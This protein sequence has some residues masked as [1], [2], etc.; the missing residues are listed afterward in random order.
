[1]IGQTFS[2][3]RILEKIGGGGMGV[4]YKA[5]DSRLHRLVALKFLPEALARDPVAL[6]RFQ[7]EARAAS[8]L[9]H[10]NICT[11]HDIGEQDGRAFIVMEYVDGG[12]LSHRIA[13]RPLDTE[14]LLRFAIEIADVLATAHSAG[15]VHRD[16]KTAN[17]MIT[18]RGQAKVLDFGLAKLGMEREGSGSGPDDPTF[19]ASQLTTAGE[20]LGTVAY[21][22]PE[23][24]EGKNL[25]GRSDLFSFGAVLYEMATGRMAFEKPTKGST[26]GA[27]LHEPPPPATQFNP[28]IPQRLL[29][30]IDKALEKDR[31]LRY[32]TA[33]DVRNDL[34][35]LKRDLDSGGQERK[36][37]PANPGL[38]PG[39]TRG[40][41]PVSR[42]GRA[43]LLYACAGLLLVLGIAGAWYYLERRAG[44][45]LT[46]KDTIV[47]AD[48]ANSTGDVVFD[49]SLKTALGLSL[50]QSPF[51][52]SLSE[53]EV[54]RT[55]RL[56]ARPADEKLTP[57]VARDL[58]LRAG[59]KAYIAGAVGSLGSKYVLEL[60]AVD[61]KTGDAL[62]EE[63]VTAESKATVLDA[64]GKAASK[65]RS[66]LGESLATVQKFD[67]PL[68]DAT[69]PSLDALKAYSLGLDAYNQKGPA[70]ALPYHLR[71]IQLDPNFAI[72]YRQLG[73]DY[74]GLTEPGRASEYYTKA[75]QLQE[76]ASERER[77][78]IIADYYESVTG[79]L[80]KAMDAYQQEIEEFP[81]VIGAYS[82]LGLVYA[83]LGEFEE[84]V[85]VTRQAVARGPDRADGYLNLLDDFMY[86]QRFEDARQTIRQAQ[87]KNIDDVLL[88]NALYALTFLA[89][90]AAGM[91][92]QQ[93]WYDGQ[94]DYQNVGLAL[95]ADSEAYGGR[96]RKSRQ[97]SRQGADSAVKADAKENAA[98]YLGLSAK[99]EAAFGNA[100]EARQQAAEAEKLAPASQAAKLEAAM[101][102]ALAGETG[103][104]EL[105]AQ[106]LDKRYP[107]DTQL[108]SIWLPTIRAQL[109][110]D[111]KDP[112]AALRALQST[113]PTLELANVQFL[114]NGSCLDFAYVRG[115]A[116][117]AAGEGAA[118]AG[119]FQKI[120]DHSG[121][122]WNCWTGALAHLGV[123]RANVLQARTSQGAD[124]DAAR[125]RALA[126]Y[127]EFLTLWKDAD[128]DIP[129]YRQAKAEYARLQ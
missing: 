49:H 105:L 24:I 85:E 44:G 67:V 46:E 55:L 89:G 99:R 9:N 66:R 15:I 47:L 22:S 75:F 115:Q 43:K 111:R 73:S 102:F 123:A 50:G 7:R 30:V 103:H 3:Y 79:E 88:H 21:M 72:A 37:E 92:E 38:S 2:H 64:L 18:Q 76:H 34:Q 108:Q 90:D 32:Q 40:R 33:D 122:V 107:R 58:C 113:N 29:E 10:P 26:F 114:I 5:E 8:A 36:T 87:G 116:Y 117:L 86:L 109:A 129:I 121:L 4:V 93:R 127:K 13:G 74:W 54:L 106:D 95:R 57:E 128:P 96:L 78:S 119:E 52:K 61:C 1:M 25:D 70:A 45:R 68:A 112:S 101:G 11:I 65:L 6:A 63:Q 91:A 28:A 62:A 56:M 80:D 125:V 118:A 120:L 60:K 104:A 126:A 39:I 100:M 42:S 17:I 81:R 94:A 98:V 41:G 31:E 48:F 16:I 69:T 71:A 14:S 35:R 59:S 82:N 20:T 23:Q 97:L 53:M 19:A 51:L 27:I 124:A 110:L 84:A 83:S 12:V 77:L